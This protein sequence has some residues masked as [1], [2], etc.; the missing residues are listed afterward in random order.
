MLS[1]WCTLGPRAINHQL[2]YQ[3][4]RKILPKY[5]FLHW[6]WFGKA[7]HDISTKME[8]LVTK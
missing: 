8:S 2:D 5:E 7:D 3:V 6:N 4:R 1:F